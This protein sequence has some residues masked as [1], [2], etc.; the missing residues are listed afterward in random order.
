MMG[1]M[2]TEK[3]VCS[4]LW[5][6]FN[7]FYS[8]KADVIFLQEVVP[9]AEKLLDQTL[10]SYQIISAGNDGYYT[11]ALLRCDTTKYK[12][13]SVVPYYDSLMGR[14][15]LKVKVSYTLVFLGSNM[16]VLLLVASIE[17]GHPP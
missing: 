4:S 6:L 16:V 3:H 17:R 11:M 1:I 14:N 13:H 9:A 10:S 5:F 12:D 7:L 8:E 2:T 15:L